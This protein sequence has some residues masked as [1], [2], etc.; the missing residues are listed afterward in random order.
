GVT[1]RDAD[2]APVA[3]DQRRELPA[4]RDVDQPGDHALLL[5]G[6]GFAAGEPP[7]FA[8]LPPLCVE[9]GVVLVVELLGPVARLG[10]CEALVDDRLQARAL[11]DDRRGLACAG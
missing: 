11:A 4:L 3:D 2:R 10:L 1:Q 5:F 6:Q 9:A 8:R 7:P